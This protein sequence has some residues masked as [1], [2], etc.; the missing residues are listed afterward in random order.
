M[1]K[2]NPNRFTIGFNKDKPSHQRVVDILNQA[3]DKAEFIAEA[4]LCYV[5]ESDSNMASNMDFGNLQPFIRELVEQ[6]IQKAVGGIR[7]Y[8]KTEGPK[9]MDLTTDEPI[10]VDTELAG[11]LFSAMDAFRRT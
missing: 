7:D 3:S 8:Q 10:P 9:V 1:G 2:K 6:E 4:V 5:G 11:D